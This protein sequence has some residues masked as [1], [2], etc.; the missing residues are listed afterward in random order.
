MQYGALSGFCC[1]WTRLISLALPQYHRTAVV[2]QEDG[3]TQEVRV[4]S[5]ATVLVPPQYRRKGY[6]QTMM[7]LLH[8][9]IAASPE[10]TDQ[11]EAGV[12]ARFSFLYSDV[13]DFYVPLGWNRAPSEQVEWDVKSLLSADT[14]ALPTTTAVQGGDIRALSALDARLTTEE[15]QRR[16][17][18]PNK[19]VLSIIEHEG[20]AFEWMVRRAELALGFY[21]R[22][23]PSVWGA[24]ISNSNS[25]AIWTV[26]AHPTDKS[27][28]E[29]L[30]LRWRYDSASELLALARAAADVANKLDIGRVTAWNVNTSAAG[31]PA[32]VESPAE[33]AAWIATSLLGGKLVERASSIPNY[34]VYPPVNGRKQ[35]QWLNNEKGWWC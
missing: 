12:P 10:N 31:L 35:V 19:L 28:E 18:D 25:F 11:V 14:A 15:L 3:T 30:L 6:A 22:Q 29:I 13:G 26:A 1:W 32:T 9:R 20:H 5:V 4:Q 24:R 2:K 17:S 33:R 27:K 8:E 16:P 21:G 34:A 23:P 7:Q